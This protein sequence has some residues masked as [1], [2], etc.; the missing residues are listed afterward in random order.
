MRFGFWRRKRLNKSM[1]QRASKPRTKQWQMLS[2][3]LFSDFVDLGVSKNGGTQQP[4]GFPAK[5]DHF[6]VFWDTAI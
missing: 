1:E 3:Q 6:G 2:P 5:N 4:W